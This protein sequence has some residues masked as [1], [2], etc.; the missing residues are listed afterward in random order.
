[1]GNAHSRIDHFWLGSQPYFSPYLIV[2]PQEQGFVPSQTKIDFFDIEGELFNSAKVLV[3]SPQVQCIA[4]E[5][6]LSACKVESGIKHCHL[7]TETESDGVEVFCRLHSAS[8]S[9]VVGKANVLNETLPGF[10]PIVL[11][12]G[13]TN[14]MALMNTDEQPGIVKVRLYIGNR[15][16]EI[17]VSLPASGLKL[18]YLEEE[19]K[20][21]IEGISQ[22]SPTAI[23]QQGYIRIMAKAPIAV[24]LLTKE[25]TAQEV[26]QF[27][28]LG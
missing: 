11:E 15:N 27:S 21:A 8:N 3:D 7:R 23:P 28:A 18:L 5:P 14:L 13:V 19:F 22:K 20:E 9:F 1:M 16:P 4:L 26:P 25:M 12:E 24:Q 17:T 6:F 10:F 2:F